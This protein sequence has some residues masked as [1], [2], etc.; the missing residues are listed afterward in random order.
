[1]GKRK[2]CSYIDA[3]SLAFL[4][5]LNFTKSR[6]PIVTSKL[7]GKLCDPAGFTANKTMFASSTIA[8]MISTK[9]MSL[10]KF[11]RSGY[12]PQNSRIILKA[13]IDIKS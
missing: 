7:T 1:V 8:E 3:A 11:I 13:Q 2:V 6:K 10:S 5:L 4:A 9:L 12:M